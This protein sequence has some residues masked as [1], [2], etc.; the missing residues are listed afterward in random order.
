VL[1]LLF[2]GEF[3]LPLA[4]EHRGEAITGNTGERTDEPLK[5]LHQTGAE[6]DQHSSLNGRADDAG[7]LLTD[8]NVSARRW[9][10]VRDRRGRTAT[11]KP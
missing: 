1:A 11:L 9:C 5:L 6:H 4:H 2:L 7:P 3:A 8:Q 10:P